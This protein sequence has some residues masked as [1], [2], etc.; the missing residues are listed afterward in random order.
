MS[1][2]M[3]VS[4]AGA[5]GTADDSLDSVK[6]GIELQADVVE[7]DIRFDGSLPVLSHDP[8]KPNKKYET[9]YDAVSLISKANQLGINA[10]M[11]EKE[12]PDGLL[13]LKEIFEHFNMKDRMYFTGIDECNGE[14][15]QKIFPDYEFLTNWNINPLKY[16]S[17][18]YLQRLVRTAKDNGFTGF[19]LNYRYVTEKM[20]EFYHSHNMKIYVWTME[21]ESD[22]E[23]LAKWGVDSITT[24]NPP[25]LQI[26]LKR[27][28]L[29]E[30]DADTV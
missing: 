9:V 26:V 18:V 8:I 12:S 16:G 20:I 6:I 23:R 17:D 22:M 29:E 15:L 27:C 5:M 28:K 11:K 10:D 24:R 30:N 1:K 25:L 7:L 21:K 14:L 2:I 4:H 13:A 19:N 3:V